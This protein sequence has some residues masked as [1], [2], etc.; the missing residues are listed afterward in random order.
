MKNTQQTFSEDWERL[1]SRSRPGNFFWYNKITG[2]IFFLINVLS[3]LPLSTRITR[4]RA[5]WILPENATIKK[6]E[7]TNEKKNTMDHLLSNPPLQTET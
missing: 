1:E 6:K 2:M 7:E 3:Q 4:R 5:T